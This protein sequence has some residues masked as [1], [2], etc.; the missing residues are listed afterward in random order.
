MAKRFIDT[1][2]FNDEWFM[3]LS[4]D[5]KL[6]YIYLITNCDHAGIIEL[7]K[8]LCQF[9]T[10]IKDF[11]RVRQE[12][13]NRLVTVQDNIYFLP[14]F[15]KFQ[16]PN[17]PQ[18]NVK[19]QE[20]AIKI[21]ESY[22]LFA[23]GCLTVSKDLAKDY[24]NDNVNDSVSVNDNKPNYKDFLAYAK[25][26]EIFKDSMEYQLKAKYN[27]WVEN[28]WKDGYNKPIKN[29]KTKLQNVLVYFKND[30]GKGYQDKK[31]TPSPE[32]QKRL[33]RD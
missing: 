23:E 29:W 11:E 3:D 31:F 33:K 22:G 18:S 15:I 6:F 5:A 9:Q 2:L 1:N 20:S 8:K 26:Q 32:M 4:K 24:D 10:D 16:Y 13:G 7:N 30:N 17:F 12:L 21:L 28:N 25:Q 14:K 19:Q 27:Q